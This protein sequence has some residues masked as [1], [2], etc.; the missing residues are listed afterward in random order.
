[1]KRQ[2]IKQ[3]KEYKGRIKG[4]IKGLCI[5]DKHY[6]DRSHR[7]RIIKGLYTKLFESE[8]LNYYITIIPDID[9]EI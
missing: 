1:M 3:A 4:Y 6:I 8:I 5:I 9:Y 7:N 2:R